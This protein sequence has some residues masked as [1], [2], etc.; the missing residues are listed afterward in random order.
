MPNGGESLLTR[1]SSAQVKPSR[2]QYIYASAWPWM[3]AIWGLPLGCSLG[4]GI[5]SGAA[6][7]VSVL[8]HTLWGA[9]IGFIAAAFFIGPTQRRRGELNGP[10]HVGDVVRILA[11]PHRDREARVCEVWPEQQT[12]RLDVGDVT[13][14]FGEDM[15][16]WYQ[17][18]RVRAG[19]AQV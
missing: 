6:D 2:A 8:P 7:F 18:V 11:K 10:F 5:G 19:E 14:R 3:T 13:R 16:G 1:G 12:A 4:V 15:F 9:L 17:L